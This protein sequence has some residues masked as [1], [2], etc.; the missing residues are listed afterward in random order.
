MGKRQDPLATARTLAVTWPAWI[1]TAA[2]RAAYVLHWTSLK[3]KYGRKSN[4]IC[5]PD[6]FPFRFV[7]L[8]FRDNL[9][10]LHLNVLTFRL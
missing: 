9:L 8:N 7:R 2:F 5:E 3:L 1:R 6:F 10:P 4:G